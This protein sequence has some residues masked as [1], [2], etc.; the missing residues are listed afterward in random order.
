MKQVY[1]L[2]FTVMLLPLI[3]Y[4]V[5]FHPEVKEQLKASGQLEKMA[6][7]YRDAR[8]RGVD[9]PAGNALNVK[10]VLENSTT[11]Q[12]NGLILLVDFADNQADTLNHPPAEF[13]DLLF[14]T[15][16][17][18]T[19]SMNDFYLENSNNKMGI[20]GLVTKWVRM[21]QNYSYYVDGQ[22]GFGNYPRNAQ[23]MVE[24]AVAAADSF[25][26]FSQYDNDGDGYVDA[27][28]VVHSGP[29]RET[30]GSDNDIHS[31]AWSI[32]PQMRDGVIIQRYSMEPETQSNH[33]VTMGVFA[34]EFGHVLGLPDLYD[35]DYSTSGIGRW[36]VMAG[37]SWA[38]PPGLSGAVPVHFDAWCKQ[39]LGWITP[40]QLSGDS[41]GVN[42]R[43]IHGD[44][45]T[46]RLWTNGAGGPEFF[47]L[48]YKKKVGFDSYLPGEGLLIWHIDENVPGNS[49]ELHRKVDL[50]QADGLNQLSFNGNSGDSGD[51]FPGFTNNTTFSGLTNPNSNNYQGQESLVAVVNIQDNGNGATADLFTAFPLPLV[52]ILEMTVND[53][54]GDQQG[55]LDPGEHV[56]FSV[57]VANVGAE[58]QNIAFD[59][60][61]PQSYV[62]LLNTQYTLAT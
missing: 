12:I 51:P 60:Q 5:D 62:S 41:M 38:G 36:S 20:S 44:S 54:L 45:S 48:E 28:F 24:D 32:N 8:Q 7:E 33:F 1:K 42:I 6:A 46:Y 23:K 52:R 27:L 35:T 53:S 61:S 29:G 49:N 17:Y 15:G 47:L 22:A 13:D 30:T 39:D 57:K 2:I 58:T 31:H 59:L 3:G 10:N 18:T 43:P 55:D 56:W 4:S 14:S 40:T 26:D 16:T 50:E 34:H 25:V 9:N 37:G 11:F 21:P 19:G